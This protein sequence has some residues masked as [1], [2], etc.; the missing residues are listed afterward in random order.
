M[1]D[2]GHRKHRTSSLEQINDLL[3]E[4]GEELALAR[5]LVHA[6]VLQA[7]H[8]PDWPIPLLDVKD[9]TVDISHDLNVFDLA[10]SGFVYLGLER[11]LLL[12]YLPGYQLEGRATTSFHDHSLNQIPNSKLIQTLSDR[13]RAV[14]GRL[15]GARR[16]GEHLAR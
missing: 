9:V 13:I 2:F 12:A 7:D 3:S 16:Y 6:L 5:I 14:L 15:P 4:G 1:Y 8:S 11:L 10:P